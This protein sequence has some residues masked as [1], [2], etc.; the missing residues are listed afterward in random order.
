M[1]H[2]H[3]CYNS[4]EEIIDLRS[5]SRSHYKQSSQ[6]APPSPALFNKEVPCT[7]GHNSTQQQQQ[8]WT[9]GTPKRRLNIR[10]KSHLI[11][12]GQLPNKTIPE[13]FATLA[14]TERCGNV[15]QFFSHSRSLFATRACFVFSGKEIVVVLFNNLI[16]R[17]RDL[18]CV[19][20]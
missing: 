2:R 18:A 9:L 10:D 4:A 7:G 12:L 8:Q 13:P 5:P 15:Q 20:P 19:W 6:P 17:M 11:T 14:N 1:L 3:R 16:K